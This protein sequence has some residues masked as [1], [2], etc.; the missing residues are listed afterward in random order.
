M[1]RSVGG[2][3]LAAAAIGG[4]PNAAYKP[5]NAGSFIS[6]ISSTIGCSS[7]ISSTTG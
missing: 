2:R 3:K 7:M 1:K 6:I 4:K 5:L